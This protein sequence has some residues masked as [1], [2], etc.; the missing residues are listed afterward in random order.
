MPNPQR[1]WTVSINNSF[2]STSDQVVQFQ[3]AVL[4]LKQLMTAAGW[5][6]VLSSNTVTAS[7]ADNWSTTSDIVLGLLGNGS[8]IVLQSPAAFGSTIQFLLYVDNASGDTTPQDINVRFTSGTYSGGTTTTLPTASVTATAVF[9][10]GRSI[11]PW[12]AVLNG[13][14]ASWRSTR[15]DVMFGVKQQADSQFRFFFLFMSME[16]ASGGGTGNYR[17]FMWIN[18]ATTDA[19]IS[20]TATRGR[21]FVEDGS[22]AYVDAMPSS[23]LFEIAAVTNGFDMQGRGMSDDIEIWQAGT[24]PRSMGTLVD[25]QAAYPQTDPAHG[26]VIDGEHTQ[27]LRRVRT[28]CLYLYMPTASLPLR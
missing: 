16:D 8:W 13:R 26:T 22:A 6:V 5:T 9:T 7:A 20:F 1:T 23:A 11:I 17:Q 12:T 24:R 21:S 15:G 14:W 19:L 2:S 4:G 10:S 27:T 3:E 28:G 18:S 25:V